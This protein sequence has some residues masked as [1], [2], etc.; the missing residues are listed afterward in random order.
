LL[1]AA[2]FSKGLKESEEGRMQWNAIKRL[3]FWN[4]GREKQK[5]ESKRI[6]LP[7]YFS[8]NEQK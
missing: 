4:K 3:D 7:S 6:L 8:R 1:K 5:D 2:I